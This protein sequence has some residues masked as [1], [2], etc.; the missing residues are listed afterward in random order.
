PGPFLYGMQ[1][2]AFSVPAGLSSLYDTY[3]DGMLM[4]RMRGKRKGEWQEQLVATRVQAGGVAH[5]A[6]AVPTGYSEMKMPSLGDFKLKL[7]GRKP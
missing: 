1:G 4:L 6:F 3:K 5:D 2:G 7:P